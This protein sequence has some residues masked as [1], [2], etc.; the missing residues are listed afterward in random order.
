MTKV[1]ADSFFFL[2][3][4][5]VRD[6]QHRTAVKLGRM[7]AGPIYTTQWVLVEVADAF[8][9]PKDRDRF[10]DL[11]ELIAA[12]ERIRVIGASSSS[13]TRGA[14]LF[15][16]RKDKNW[17]LTDCISFVAMEDR[18]ITD[19][20]TGDHHFEQAGFTVLLPP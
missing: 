1:F 13:F 8:S 17:S 14:E 5:N 20:L 10:I 7:L 19:A 15:R 6:S 11:L 2:A 9:K 3:M 4:L 12:D 18:H 16:R